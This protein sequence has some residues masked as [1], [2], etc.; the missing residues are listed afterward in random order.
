MYFINLNLLMEDKGF[1]NNLWFSQNIT[2]LADLYVP[3]RQ[4]FCMM[5][6]FRL[7]SFSVFTLNSGYVKCN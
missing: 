2:C 1:S 5:L 6:K 3:R 4:L 7:L